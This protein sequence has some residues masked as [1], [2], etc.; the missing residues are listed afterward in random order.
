[1]S[2]NFLSSIDAVSEVEVRKIAIE[3]EPYGALGTGEANLSWVVGPLEESCC[4]LGTECGRAAG[5]RG[6][7]EVGRVYAFELMGTLFECEVNHERKD[8]EKPDAE[9]SSHASEVA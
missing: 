7:G 5:A 6:S 2:V 8:G 4:S 9:K 3:D 1:V